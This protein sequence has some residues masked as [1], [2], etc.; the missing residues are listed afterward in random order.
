[1][2]EQRNL[3]RETNTKANRYSAGKGTILTVLEDTSMLGKSIGTKQS[4]EQTPSMFY[5]VVDSFYLKAKTSEMTDIDKQQT[6]RK[7]QS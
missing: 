7:R 4:A 6:I 2:R 3:E 5:L 1:V